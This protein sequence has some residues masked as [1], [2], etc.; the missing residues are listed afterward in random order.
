VVSSVP[1]VASPSLEDAA[2]FFEEFHA[3]GHLAGVLG[4]QRHLHLV[5]V[6]VLEGQFHALVAE[7]PYFDPF[8]VVELERC[9]ID[10]GSPV[11]VSLRRSIRRVVT[12]VQKRL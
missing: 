12:W 7:L 11:D 8:D 5:A 9:W 1:P 4:E 3:A 6:L 10:D 2:L